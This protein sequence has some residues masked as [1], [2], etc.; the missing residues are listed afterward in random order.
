VLRDRRG[1]DR[2]VELAGYFDEMSGEIETWWFSNAPREEREA[3]APFRVPRFHR[4][5]GSWVGMI[6]RAGFV[7]QEFGEPSASEELASEIPFIADTRVA[8]LFLH[9]RAVKPKK[10]EM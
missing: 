5:L 10:L 4:T 9:A 1:R 6:C 8:A 7:I 3:V 2:A